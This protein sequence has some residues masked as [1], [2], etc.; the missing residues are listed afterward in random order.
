M[1][2]FR[3][4]GRAESIRTFLRMGAEA[5]APVGFGLLA[6]AL[7]AGEPRSAHGVQYT[8]LIMLVPLAAN[9]VLLLRGRAA[10]PRDVATAIMSEEVSR[11]K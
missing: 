6:D 9:A 10:Y 3:L 7:G 4:W 2:H 8:F 11:R 1:V 5:T